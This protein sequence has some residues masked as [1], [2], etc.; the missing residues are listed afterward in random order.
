MVPKLR[1]GWESGEPRHVI[2]FVDGRKL[3]GDQRIAWPDMSQGHVP[4]YGK[5]GRRDPTDPPPASA[6]TRGRSNS[7]ARTS[8]DLWGLKNLT[9]KR[10]QR[11]S[12]KSLWSIRF[13]IGQSVYTKAY[14]RNL[15]VVVKKAIDTKKVQWRSTELEKYLTTRCSKSFEDDETDT[16]LCKKSWH[17]NAQWIALVSPDIWL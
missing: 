15:F 13:R 8:M 11:T 17:Q 1:L 6:D 5:V 3:Y 4:T 14:L 9:K 16:L 12:P 2:R 7:T 10:C